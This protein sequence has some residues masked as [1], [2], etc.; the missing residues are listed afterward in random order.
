MTHLNATFTKDVGTF[1][2]SWDLCVSLAL[3]LSLSLPPCFPPPLSLS[4]FLSQYAIHLG[5][6]ETHYQSK[7]RTIVNKGSSTI[8]LFHFSQ[9]GFFVSIGSTYSEQSVNS[10]CTGKG[11]SLE[12]VYNISNDFPPSPNMMWPP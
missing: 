7:L 8:C 6:S 4:V 11:A 2:V 1:V 5:E 3:S 9:S 12:L 10:D